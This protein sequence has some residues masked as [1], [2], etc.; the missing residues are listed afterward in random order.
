MA[1]NV[2]VKRAFAQEEYD[3]H[4]LAELQKCMD[5]P[6]YFMR[7][8]IVIQHPT[9]G[10]IPFD[11]YDFQEDLVRQL[12]D[13]EKR[14]NII[15]Q[16]RQSGKSTVATAFLVWW[17]MFKPDQTILVLSRGMSHAIEL[18]DR[19]RFSWE[20]L[21]SWLKAGVKAY[22]KSTIEFD[23]GSKI[24]S[25]PATEKS[26]RGYSISLLYWDETAFCPPRIT[27][28]LWNSLFPTL[29]TGGR[30]I[31]TS[32]PNG[33]VDLFSTL[34]RGALLG[35][36]T[37]FHFLATWEKV[38]GRDEKWKEEMIGAI[39]Q[40][41]F[42]QECECQF[43]S[44]DPLLI[45]S[46]K[47]Q[48]IVSSP[49]IG[50]Q[51]MFQFWKSIEYNKIYIIGCDVGSGTGSD[52]ST[53][54]VLEFPTLIQTAQFRSNTVSLPQLYG[55]L[56]WI[57]NFIVQPTGNRKGPEVF[58]SWENNSIG[59]SIIALY[60][61]DETPP[62]GELVNADPKNFG[63]N[64]NSKTKIMACL[65]LKSLI[66]KNTNGLII[67]SDLLLA[68]LKNYVAT[69]ISYAAKPGATDDLVSS[70][71]VCMQIIKKMAEYDENAF[72]LTYQYDEINKGLDEDGNFTATNPDDAE[73]FGI[74]H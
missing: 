15:M 18:M 11:M 61:N 3:E 14:F 73:P 31:I 38:P 58:W 51:G 12:V 70:L 23:N 64:T 48:T 28:K 46:L 65:K 20:E 35:T 68:E 71:L 6:V 56:K 63:V 21:P 60:Q 1:T 45:S 26:G 29:S 33:D 49:P 2:L 72:K 22:N 13:P 47:L 69:G 55:R 40:L 43:L 37:F 32:T 39:G 66:E 54:N 34:W 19:I 57:V 25:Q 53:I 59:H 50:E 4:K 52:Y 9:R 62:L 36:N 41:S 27:T 24:I 42:E 44:S 5:D 8:Y 16:C 67:N 7:T 17:T 30:C 74:F 10:S